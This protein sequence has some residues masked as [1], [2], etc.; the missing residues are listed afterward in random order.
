MFL[1]KNG[2]MALLLAFGLMLVVEHGIS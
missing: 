2:L 1:G